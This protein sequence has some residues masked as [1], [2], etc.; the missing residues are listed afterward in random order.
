[1]DIIST[2]SFKS[3]KSIFDKEVS[4][5]KNNTVRLVSKEEDETLENCLDNIK[6]IT[7]SCETICSDYKRVFL[8]E[9]KDITRIEQNNIIF[10]I[11][12]WKI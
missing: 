11:F 4:G 6:Y 2:V 1:M 5:I 7:I 12:A 9:I 3:V 10:Y 8:R